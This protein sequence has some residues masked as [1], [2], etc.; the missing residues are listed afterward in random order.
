MNNM[1]YNNQHIKELYSSNKL[2][3]KEVIEL[4][5][6][7]LS[8]KENIKQLINLNTKQFEIINCIND[9]VL[10]KREKDIQEINN[11]LIELDSI[12]DTNII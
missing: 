9:F 4:K 7:V 2:L 5:G 10:E 8:L 3:T 12:I 6:D 1:S 11:N